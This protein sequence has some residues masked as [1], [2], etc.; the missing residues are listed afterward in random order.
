MKIRYRRT[1]EINLE[2]EHIW[3]LEYEECRKMKGRV[4]DEPSQTGETRVSNAAA[5]IAGSSL[6]HLLLTGPAFLMGITF[7][8]R[9]HPIALTADIRSDVLASESATTRLHGVM[10]VGGIIR[11]I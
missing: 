5:K 8:I 2:N 4:S 6:N 7:R 9:E 3:Q 1:I 11:M 10:F